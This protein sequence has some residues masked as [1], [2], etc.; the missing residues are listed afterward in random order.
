M[1][2]RLRKAS[3]PVALFAN[4]KF[5]KFVPNG[6]LNRIT[7]RPLMGD[8]E[9]RADELEALQSIFGAEFSFSEHTEDVACRFSIALTSPAGHPLHLDVSLP[10]DYPSA[11]APSLRLSGPNLPASMRA[12]ALSAL[13]VEA[14]AAAGEVAVFRC[15]PHHLQRTMTAPR[16]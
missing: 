12:A 8:A 2:P 6:E 7:A 14:R 10:M 15:R 4:F 3:Q 5:A 11:G 13:Q 9:Q 16:I 1:Y